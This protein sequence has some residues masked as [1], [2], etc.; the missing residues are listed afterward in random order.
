MHRSHLL[1]MVWFA[2][3][4]LKRKTCRRYIPGRLLFEILIIVKCGNFLLRSVPYTSHVVQYGSVVTYWSWCTHMTNNA[5]YFNPRCCIIQG[6][7]PERE[8][9]SRYPDANV[10]PRL[11][12]CHGETRTVISCGSHECC[13]PADSTDAC[14]WQGH[15]F[16]SGTRAVE[17]LTR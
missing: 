8:Y 15:F 5:A 2:F 6:G 17:K 3:K 1:P 4:K 10:F 12:Q 7:T 13:L 11:E 14:R 16:L 9:A